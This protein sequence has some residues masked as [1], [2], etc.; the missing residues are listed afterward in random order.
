MLFR[1]AETIVKHEEEMRR[2][3]D[4]VLKVVHIIKDRIKSRVSNYLWAKDTTSEEVKFV[5][6]DICTQDKYKFS[7]TVDNKVEESNIRSNCSIH[8]ERAGRASRASRHGAGGRNPRRE[9][10]QEHYRHR[11]VLP[12]PCGHE[13]EQGGQDDY[14]HGVQ[15]RLGQLVRK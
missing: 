6:V 12:L 1:S 8:D 14:G 7:Y 13:Q 2:D 15:A 4:I 11:I 10:I 5:I 3:R 9:G